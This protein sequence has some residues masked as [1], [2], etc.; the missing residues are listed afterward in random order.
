MPMSAVA[1]LVTA[2]AV[3]LMT[4]DDWIYATKALAGSNGTL[5]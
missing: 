3:V 2:F 5:A 4:P 1:K